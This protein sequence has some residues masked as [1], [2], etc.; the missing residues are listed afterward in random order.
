MVAIS[1]KAGPAGTVSASIPRGPAHFR[2]FRQL[3][4]VE[5]FKHR[6]TPARVPVAAKVAQQHPVWH[7]DAETFQPVRDAPAPAQ[8]DGAY[9]SGKI[10]EVSG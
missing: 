5:R 4:D 6:P 1:I 9:E 7:L 2:E 10:L 8:P 3:L